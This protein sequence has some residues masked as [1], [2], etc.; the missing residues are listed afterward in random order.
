MKHLFLSLPIAVL[1]IGCTVKKPEAP[2][3]SD[4]KVEEDTNQSVNYG[5]MDLSVDPKSDFYEY[6]NGTWAKNNP[7]PSSETK[8]GSFNELQIDNYDKIKVILETTAKQKNEKGS[9]DQL[10]GDYYYT[11]LNEEARMK[12]GH[13]SIRKSAY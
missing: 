4:L 13:S 8:W 11:F 7:V 1:A 6:A 12:E 10:I 2:K 9:V 5:Y 3:A